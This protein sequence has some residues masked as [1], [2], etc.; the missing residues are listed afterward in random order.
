V[1]A[2]FGLAFPDGE[3]APAEAAKGA[4]G[5]AVAVGVAL[6]FGEPVGAAGGGDAAC[7]AVVHVP[8][9]AADE[10]DFFEAWEDEVRRA[11]EG[12]DVAAVGEAEGVDD[13]ADGP[14]R[15]GVSRSLGVSSTTSSAGSVYF[16]GITYVLPLSSI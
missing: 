9:A 13:A 7:A 6:D 16:S 8:E 3:D 2:G 14:K 5:A 10:D 11:G 1:T 12:G 4:A 15:Q